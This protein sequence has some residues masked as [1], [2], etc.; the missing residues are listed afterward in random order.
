M[1]PS[2]T[3]RARASGRACSRTA[4]A[5]SASEALHA[6][7]SPAPRSTRARSTSTARA[8]TRVF[9]SSRKLHECG[10]DEE[11][12]VMERMLDGHSLMPRHIAF[13]RAIN[14]GGHTV[15]MDRLRE[16]LRG[17]GPQGRRD[18]HRER[19]R[20]LP[21]AGEGQPSLEAK[22]ERHLHQALGYEVATFI[23]SEA[24]VAAVA[25]IP[26]VQATAGRLRRRA[27][28]WWV[29]ARATRRRRRTQR[30]ARTQDRHRRPAREWPRAV[31]AHRR[32][33][34]ATRQLTNALFERTLKG[35]ATF[36]NINTVTRL[37]ARYPIKGT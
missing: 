34:R 1:D 36:R 21:L 7:G 5:S 4:R 18:L 29:P 15:T 32:A 2:R 30:R 33:G 19:Q 26:A 27:W 25:G 13:L 22:I 9:R 16:P 3:T 17:T 14:V 6:A 23:R 8:D 10:V 12:F 28:S 11:S 35:K 24:E 31:L 20:D 37:A